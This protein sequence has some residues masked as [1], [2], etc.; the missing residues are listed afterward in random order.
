MMGTWLGTIDGCGPVLVHRYQV[1]QYR[2]AEHTGGE[3]G[4]L[5]GREA[6]GPDD[7]D[8]EDG[9]GWNEGG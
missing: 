8:D 1:A 2:S 6:G 9:V 5:N 4:E 7:E 3:D